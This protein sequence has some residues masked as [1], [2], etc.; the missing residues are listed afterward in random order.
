MMSTHMSLLVLC[1]YPQR[2]TLIHGKAMRLLNTFLVQHDIDIKKNI[3]Y[4]TAQ[5][6]E[7]PVRWWDTGSTAPRRFDIVIAEFAPLIADVV[8]TN[9]T[10]VVTRY[11]KPGGRFFLPIKQRSGPG[12][13][14]Y[15]NG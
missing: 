13:L 2:R 12:L 9:I 15:R 1:V 6:S 11:L 7:T 8:K 10:D 3:Y 5:E 4:T 14:F